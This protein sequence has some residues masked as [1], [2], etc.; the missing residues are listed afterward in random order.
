MKFV[1]TH[2]KERGGPTIS[3]IYLEG[4]TMSGH[5]LDTCAITW[6]SSAPEMSLVRTEMGCVCK[7]HTRFQR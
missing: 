2:F 3:L 4:S 6:G 1:I 7:I 5:T